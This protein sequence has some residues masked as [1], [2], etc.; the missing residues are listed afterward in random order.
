MSRWGGGG[1]GGK[2][3]DMTS[4]DWLNRKRISQVKKKYLYM[5]ILNYALLQ[6]LASYISNH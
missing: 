5:Y 6:E 1:G 2:G 3:K 4:G